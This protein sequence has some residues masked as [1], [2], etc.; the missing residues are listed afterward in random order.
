[1]RIG[2][3][4][5]GVVG[6][7]TARTYLEWAEE[8]RV[9]DVVPERCTHRL[10]FVLACDIVFVCLPTPQQKESLECD[11]SVVEGFFWE[12]GRWNPV[13]NYV[14]RS[15]VP[16][17]TT[18]RLAENYCLPNLV[19]SPEFLT[20]RCAE[21]D[22]LI[23]S[24]NIIGIPGNADVAARELAALYRQR[25][26]GVDY[27]L[28]SSD[29]S[30]AVKLFTNA[31]FAVKVAFFNEIN[32]LACHLNLDWDSVRE[33]ILSDGRITANHTR[34]PGPDGKFGFGGTCLPKDLAMLAAALTPLPN[35]GVVW[36]ALHRNEVDRRRTQ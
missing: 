32:E 8:V 23:P 6:R 24:R 7:A 16:I 12:Y 11:L 18:R 13:A 19:H 17:G 21:T 3:V 33:G 29:E 28:M 2:V 34:V 27:H 36:G 25:F 26:P 1:M 35:A 31:F 15:T 14:L 9:Y 22:A 10:D 4:G 20:A 5:G 30:E